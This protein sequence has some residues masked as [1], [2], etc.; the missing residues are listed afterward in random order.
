MERGQLSRKTAIVTGASRGIG[1]A[2]ALRLAADGARVVLC[3][4]DAAALARAAQELPV[5]GEWL[6]LDLRDA[7]AQ[8]RLVQFAVETTGRIDIVVNNAGATQRGDFLSLTDAQWA[9][10]Y[11]LKLHGA[12]RLAREAWPHLKAAQGALINV[13]GTG[14]RTP[15]ADFAIGGS[16]NAALLSFTKALA[17]VGLRD[18]VRVNVINPG[19]VRTDRFDKRMATLA[20]ERGV[21]ATEAE[22]IF[23]K[24][25]KVTGVGEPEDIA[26]LVAFAVSPQ[27][28][29][30]HGA[31]IDIDGGATKT[32]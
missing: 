4:R 13:A 6:A 20:A 2:I 11:A 8:A 10:G 18:G 17:E 21:T 14:G 12:V 16:V 27:A 1:R 28:R 7:D 23:V 30:L 19:T 15:G 9:D 29:F 32:F 3:A 25:A 22:A 5:P 26:A 31:M 24:E